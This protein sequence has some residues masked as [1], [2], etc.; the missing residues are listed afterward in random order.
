MDKGD[1]EKLAALSRIAVSDDEKKE[2]LKDFENILEYVGEIKKLVVLE[3]KKETGELRNVMRAD[4]IKP[5]PSS[6]RE[7]ILSGAPARDGDYI[8]VKQ[9]FEN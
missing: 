9:I 1:I 5:A 6:S 8:K 4:E 7:E 2:F 3:P